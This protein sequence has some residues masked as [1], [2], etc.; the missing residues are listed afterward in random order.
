MLHFYASLK[1]PNMFYHGNGVLPVG[2]SSLGR[3]KGTSRAEINSDLQKT[4]R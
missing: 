4:T 1:S 3:Q 2:I